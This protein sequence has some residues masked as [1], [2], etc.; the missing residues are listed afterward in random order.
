MALN[1]GRHVF[2]ELGNLRGS[3][4]AHALIC[5]TITG[6]GKLHLDSRRR[7]WSIHVEAYVALASHVLGGERRRA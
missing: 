6:G 5:F 2:I 4:Q 3:F 7:I 1:T